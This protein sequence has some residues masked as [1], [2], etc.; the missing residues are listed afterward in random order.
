[1]DSEL[2][3]VSKL[4]GIENWNLWKFQIQIILKS[5]E[6]WDIVNGTN[7]QPAPVGTD[8]TA[9]QKKDNAEAIR[10]WNK[11][12]GMAQK[13]IVTTISEQTMM[14][15]LTSGDSEAMWKKLT[16][17]YEQKSESTIHILQQKWFTLAKDP[18]HDI[19]AHISKIEDISNRLQ[20]MGEK[21]E[22]KGVMTKILLT[23]PPNFDH[24]ISAW[25]STATTDRTLANLTSRLII[26]EMRQSQ[27]EVEVNAL[28]SNV[29]VSSK[30]HFSKNNIGNKN[31][32]Y[33]KNKND[34]RKNTKR[35]PGKCNFCHKPGHW[36]AECWNNPES[37][38]YK[39]KNSKVSGEERGEALISEAFA[40]V[41]KTAKTTV[42][43]WYMD[44]GASDHMTHKLEWFI[45]YTPMKD[46]IKIKIGDGETI[47]GNGRGSIN[48]SAFNGE[49]WTECHLSNVLYVPKLKYNLFS[50]GVA[51]DKNLTL[52]ADK[53]ICKFVKEGKTIAVGERQNK[54]F[55]MKIKIM[56]I[57]NG[58]ES[59]DEHQAYVAEKSSFQEW[60]QKLAHQNYTQIKKILK[61][62]DINPKGDDKIVCE[63]CAL[64]KIHRLPFPQQS[65][66]KTSRIGQI[67]H[68]DVCGPL[69]EKS[70]TG[71]KYFLL[72]K[73]DYSHYR[74][75]Y[76]LGAKS[77]VLEC[78]K[79]Y[80]KKTEKHCP[81]GIEIFRSDNGLE[82]VNQEVTKL[83]KEY[84]ISHQNSVVYCPEQNGKIERENRTVVE[85][86]RTMLH[87]AKFELKFW[88]EAVNTAVYIL[89][90]S[91]TSSIKN[92]SPYEIW[93][94]KRPDIQE[95]HIFGEKVYVKLPENKVKK[96][97][98]KGEIGYFV[99][100]G[101]TVKG[102]RVW[103]PEEDD[104]FVRKHIIYTGKLMESTKENQNQAL[105]Y[106][107]EEENKQFKNSQAERKDDEQIEENLENLE[108]P[109]Q[110]SDSEEENEKFCTPEAERSTGIQ[111]R[112]RSKLNKPKKLEDYEVDLDNVCDYCIENPEEP[113][114]FQQ[115]VNGTNAQE[116]KQA[117]EE[118]MNSL[119]TSKVWELVEVPKNST[120]VENKWV[121]K[122]KTD[123]NG[124]IQKFR[125]R[126]VAK[127]FSQRE[128]IDF[129]ETFSP[130]VRFDSIRILLTVIVQENLVLK[131]FDVKTAFL[132]G[133]I[134]EVIYM[135][136]PTGFNDGTTRVCK[137]LKSLYGLRQS[138]RCWNQRIKVFLTNYG[139]N[140]SKADPC[141]YM[142]IKNNL[143]I[144]L[145][146]IYI[147]DGL[148]AGIDEE[149][150]NDFLCALEK[151]FDITSGDADTYLGL[152]IERQ[153][154]GSILLRQSAYTRKIL[155]KF[156]LEQANALAIP[157]DPHQRLDVNLNDGEKTELTTAPYREAVGSLLY[158]SK[159]TR[160]DIS[161]SVSMVSRYMEKPTK[162]HWNA[163]KRIMKYLKGTVDYGLHFKKQKTL[164]LCGYSDADFAGDI[165]TRKSTTGFIVIWSG[166]VVSWCSQRQST[167]ATSTTYSEYIAAFQT[168]K[169]IVWLL[170]LIGEIYP[171]QNIATTLYI[172]N[173]STLELIKNPVLHKR[174]KHIDVQYHYIREQYDKKVFQLK[175]INTKEQPADI[176]TKPLERRI[177][178]FHRNRICSKLEEDA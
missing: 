25:E 169:E 42:E 32:Q 6:A 81:R 134:E 19:A 34:D 104:I 92:Q 124:N 83:M 43:A 56:P 140:Q 68:A 165:E 35:K 18:S 129:N 118:E 60:H 14:H 164:S 102:N 69:P 142:L 135:K 158:L 100:Y 110:L 62:Y 55:E 99:G 146:S 147:D 63:P 70:F 143:I 66:T 114:T 111:L 78:L 155:N 97:D 153:N 119:K 170:K 45:N 40:S 125:A 12:D 141:I 15:I 22:D 47:S 64:S 131:Q 101:D 130:V 38:Q 167:V 50:G 21:I 112:D 89:N 74:T 20:A 2:S 176:L 58:K 116:W 95:F 117:M 33:V 9:A 48:I 139:L 87:A 106:L 175:Y 57:E 65:S 156:N 59:T 136:Q 13:V 163:V 79:D 103:I 61:N 52:E 90:C 137:L 88:A 75:V 37:K 166:C 85:A 51:L 150:V 123:T 16:N 10:K 77:D 67:I 159:G 72:L 17:I 173:Q 144:L 5:I 3:R 148:V 178:E 39:F 161:F 73:D 120:I 44:T 91:G 122:L 53:R 54:L 28:A 84:G 127:G 128:G 177:F 11:T 30:N 109:N 96:L 132:N 24:F 152:Q 29:R 49:K 172:D 138:S 133:D 82:F 98:L 80:I 171:Y 93:Y 46:D 105:L 126:L 168:V 160:P 86:A 108:L 151:E 31:T 7:K 27:R 154:D 26:E 174:S 145:V 121:Y 76:F 8:E 94:N 113:L 149:T 162:L 71:A 107:P 36:A 4:Q 23:L 157:A 1:M 41:Q 115:A